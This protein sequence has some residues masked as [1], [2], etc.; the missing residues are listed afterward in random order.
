[1][2][3]YLIHLAVEFIKEGKTFNQFIENEIAANASDDELR[4]I[5]NAAWF[6]VGMTENVNKKIMC[7]TNYNRATAFFR[8]LATERSDK[9][10]D[11]YADAMDEVISTCVPVT[12]CKDCKKCDLPEEKPYEDGYCSRCGYVKMDWFCADGERKET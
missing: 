11:E 1:M 5:W 6:S 4:S 7:I 12:R 8:S 9:T 3:N 10:F 2:H